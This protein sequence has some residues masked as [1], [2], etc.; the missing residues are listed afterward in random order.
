MERRWFRQARARF[1]DYKQQVLSYQ[2]PGEL[3]GKE[4]PSTIVLLSAIVLACF[5]FYYAL[6][7]D[8]LPDLYHNPIFLL[9][10]PMSFWKY[11]WSGA[12]ILILLDNTSFV[13]AEFTLILSLAYIYEIYGYYIQGALYETNKSAG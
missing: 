10:I 8:W 4:L 11:T 2:L 6:I 1:E 7:Y 9:A 5:S 12:A 3:R 13:P